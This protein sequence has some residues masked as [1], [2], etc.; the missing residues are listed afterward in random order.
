MAI[1]IICSIVLGIIGAWTITLV[2]LLKV[3]I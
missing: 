3:A 1:W 2:T